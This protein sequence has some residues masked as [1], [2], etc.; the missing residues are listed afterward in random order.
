M[1]TSRLNKTSEIVTYSG[2]V[3]DPLNPDP[4]QIRIEDIAHSLSNQ[5]RFTGHTR[6][7]YSVAQHSV[8]V[9]YL[10]DPKDALWGLL[11]DASEAYLSDIASPI[12]QFS[13]MGAIYKTV[14]EALMT[15]IAR[16]FSLEE[17]YISTGYPLY[18]PQLL[19]PHS[20]KEADYKALRIEMRDLMPA[21]IDSNL[22][23]FPDTVFEVGMC[24]TP[25]SARFEFMERF[26]E[27]DD[28]RH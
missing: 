9:S 21:G 26:K 23:E 11:H 18:G 10:C 24:L 8:L 4:E 3:I 19:L 2:A 22:G 6:E 1:I 25:T 7:F 13:D 12:K 17:K 20:V 27:L 28:A 15:A 14:E 16:C 5:C